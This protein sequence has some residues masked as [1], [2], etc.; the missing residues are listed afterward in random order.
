MTFNPAEHLGERVTIRGTAFTA[1]A[2]AI[3]MLPKSPPVY[4]VGLAEWAEEVVGKQVEVTGRLHR[5]PSR[6]PQVEPRADQYHGVAETIAL[7][8]AS[9]AVLA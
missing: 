2:G 3:V 7:D 4:I 9:W 8:D 5:R 1:R 6:I